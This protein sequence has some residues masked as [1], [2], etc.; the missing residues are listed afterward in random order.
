VR[1]WIP[2]ALVF[3]TF[4]VGLCALVFGTG[5]HGA[6]KGKMLVPLCVFG[7][8]MVLTPGLSLVF[9]IG[10]KT[11]PLLITLGV[12]GGCLVGLLLW[13]SYALLVRQPAS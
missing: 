2:L 8:L 11:K 4:T 13:F 5:F 12:G 7:A 1:I 6:A 9:A 3:T 10:G